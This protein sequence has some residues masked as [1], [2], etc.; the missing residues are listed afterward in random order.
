[1]EKLI[2]VM[3]FSHVYEY[4]NFYINK[5]YKWIDCTNLKGTNGYCDNES[6]KILEK[7]VQAINPKS[8]HF[9]DN[10]NY[11]YLSKLWLSKIKEKFILLVFDHHCDMIKPAFSNN[12]LSCGSWIMNCIEENKYLIKVIIV[13]LSNEQKNIIPNK[14]SSKVSCICDDE[15]SSNIKLIKSIKNIDNL[16][17]YISI[18][19]DVLNKKIV[20]LTWDQGVIDLENLKYTLNYFIQSKNIIGIDVCGESEVF[21]Y[22]EI[23]KNNYINLEILKL[24]NKYLT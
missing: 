11:H 13:G 6:M 19:K 1:M 14:Y 12:I 3:N 16:P 8:I 23:I 10:G 5:K 24:L 17:I 22:D 20:D 7:K 21:K 15:L 2:T 9:I 4:E 18:D